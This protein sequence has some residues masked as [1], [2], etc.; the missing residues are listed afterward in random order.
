M[1]RETTSF[2]TIWISLELLWDKRNNYLYMRY[3]GSLY[4]KDCSN[5]DS[6]THDQFISVYSLTY[7]YFTIRETIG[8]GS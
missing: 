2:M 7:L 4:A 6:Y 8:E 1:E 3:R 5:M